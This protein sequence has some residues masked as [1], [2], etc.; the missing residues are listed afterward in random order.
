M[1]ICLQTSGKISKTTA[2]IAHFSRQ[3]KPLKNL[4]ENSMKNEFHFESLKRYPIHIW[5]LPGP[6]FRVRVNGKNLEMS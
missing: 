1:T 2:Y 4:L 5:K 6:I 3:K